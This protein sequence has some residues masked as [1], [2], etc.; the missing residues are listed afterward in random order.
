MNVK[1]HKNCENTGKI[2]MTNNY[3]YILS[4]YKMYKRMQYTL[5][6]SG[7]RFLSTEN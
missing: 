7:T 5:N 4:P 2:Q 6:N 1:F 3:Y